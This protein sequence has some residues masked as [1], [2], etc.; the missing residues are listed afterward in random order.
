MPSAAHAFSRRRIAGVR[1]PRRSDPLIPAAMHQCG[2]DVLKHHPVA[3]P[4]A[5]AAQRVSGVKWRA[6]PADQRAELAPDRLQQ[7]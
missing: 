7:A 5:M 3:D 1:A 6:L 4:A 2:H